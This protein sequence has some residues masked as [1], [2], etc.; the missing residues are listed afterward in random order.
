MG[1]VGSVVN[2]PLPFSDNPSIRVECDLLSIEEQKRERAYGPQAH[3]PPREEARNASR[4]RASLPRHRRF[5]VTVACPRHRS[6]LC[7]CNVL[8]VYVIVCGVRGLHLR[9]PALE[10]KQAVTDK[11]LQ[12]CLDGP[13]WPI[14]TPIQPIS[15]ADLDVDDWLAG[16]ALR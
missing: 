2:L 5:S 7:A 10:D 11:I 9:R 4:P 6:A 1:W 13:S 14:A 8:V 16:T 12:T 3:Q 15:H